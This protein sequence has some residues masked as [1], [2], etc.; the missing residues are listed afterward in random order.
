[1]GRPSL[2]P[3]VENGSDADPF[4]T[5]KEQPPTLAEAGIDKHL[6]NESRKTNAIPD[7]EQ[8]ITNGRNRI[9]GG[10]RPT[11]RGTFGTGENEW[12]TPAE[13]IEIVRAALGG[14]IDVDPAS[15]DVAQTTVAAA[16]YY[17]TEN[18]GLKQEWSGT[19][20]LNPPYAQPIMSEFVSKLIIEIGAKRTKAAILLTH[21]Y[22]DTAWFQE[23]AGIADAICFTR[24]RVKFVD[25]NG[26]VAAPT[27]GQ[28]FFYFGKNI[29]EFYQQ[30]S[31]IGFVMNRID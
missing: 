28:A 29:K 24:G 16:V 3:A 13:Y 19:V 18:D 5:N 10:E 23:A 11:V 7:L 22:T 2:P 9:L 17:T 6:A 26:N 20:Y 8:H 14:K 25:P 30:F 12:Y 21:N 4:G 31:S 27:Q 15:S 1:V